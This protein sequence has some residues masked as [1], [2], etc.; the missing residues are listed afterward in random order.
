MAD[1]EPYKDPAYWDGAEI[2]L[3]NKLAAFAAATEYEINELTS[4]VEEALGRVEAALQNLDQENSKHERLHGMIQVVGQGGFLRMRDRSI[5][6]SVPPEG[7]G[8]W[9]LPEEDHIGE[10]TV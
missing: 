4:R 6:D 1:F 5:T 3:P 8:D 9:V 7:E 2:A 10:D